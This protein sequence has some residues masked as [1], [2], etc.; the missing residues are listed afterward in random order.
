[1]TTLRKGGVAYR[2]TLGSDVTRDCFFAEL[3][4]ETV[5][6]PVLA[7]EAVW[8]DATNDFIVTFSESV[9]PFS[10]LEVFLAE[11]R[12]RVPPAS[13]LV[14]SNVFSQVEAA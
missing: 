3:T 11:A 6:S 8:S 13:H 1:M 14:E 2:I 9:I 10:V 4:R 7:A 12:K 5:D